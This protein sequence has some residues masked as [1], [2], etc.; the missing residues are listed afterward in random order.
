[1]NP[2]SCMVL[3][4]QDQL[5]C[6]C[7][8]DFIM[9]FH[10]FYGKKK[11]NDSSPTMITGGLSFP[12]MNLC[13]MF[14]ATD[15]ASVIPIS[16]F[17]SF[18]SPSSFLGCRHSLFSSWDDFWSS[19]VRGLMELNSFPELRMSSL[20]IC[21]IRSDQNKRYFMR[22]TMKVKRK[23]GIE[24]FRHLACVL[25]CRNRYEVANFPLFA[26][27]KMMCR[28]I[29]LALE[30]WMLNSLITSFVVSCLL[31]NEKLKYPM[32]AELHVLPHSFPEQG[33]YWKDQVQGGF[34]SSH[35]VPDLSLLFQFRPSNLYLLQPNS[36]IVL[37]FN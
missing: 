21:S 20:M 18:F 9:I 33:R 24:W 17:H 36:R 6:A 31:K 35:L 1:M 30:N 25:I 22:D 14:P 10:V 23:S 26:K 11:E 12:S 32:N 16:H 29:D 28:K 15:D 4:R 19:G 7:M 3:S 8:A 5:N 13:A 37:F 34:V 2:T 27:G